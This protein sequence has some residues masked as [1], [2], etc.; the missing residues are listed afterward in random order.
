MQ[1]QLSSTEY[2]SDHQEYDHHEYVVVA[3]T[4]V[5]PVQVK[6]RWRTISTQELQATY[7][8]CCTSS[9]ACF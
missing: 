4:D 8:V 7:V 9:G 6:G 3:V 1:I 2:I 5:S